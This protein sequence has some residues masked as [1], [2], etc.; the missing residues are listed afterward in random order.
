MR[1]GLLTVLTGLVL[2]LPGTL[3]ADWHRPRHSVGPPEPPP[4][5]LPPTERGNSEPDAAKL[6]STGV[7]SL[8]PI[9]AGRPGYRLLREADAQC[10]AVCHAS[11]ANLL[12][13]ERAQMAAAHPSPAKCKSVFDRGSRGWK[14]R[15]AI[16]YYAALEDRN[17]AAGQALPLYFKAAQL[18]AQ[19]NLLQFSR[20]E[21]AGS[22]RKSEELSAKGFSQ[23][24]D[25]GALKRQLLDVEA[26]MVRARAGLVEVNGRLKGLIGEIDCDGD[27]LW[28]AI[29]VP[30]NFEGVDPEAAVGIAL[31]HR[32]ELLLLREMCGD[33]DKETLP[34]VRDYLH[35]VSGLL[36][37]S[38]GPAKCVAST[39]AVLKAFLSGGD[40]EKESR[41]SQIASM[42]ADRE[43]AV[44]AEVRLAVADFHAK[45]RI[46]AL[47]RDRVQSA[48]Q[49]RRDAEQ[50]AL[51]AG[52]TFLEVTSARLDWFKARNLLTVDVMAWHTARAK[53]RE[54]QGI[55][56]WECCEEQ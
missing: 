9:V 27:W 43:R 22:I 48:D 49:H 44:A 15:R 39:L 18:E 32:P 33:L 36:G 31:T 26:D 41:Q 30:V 17:R 54:T 6:P 1:P 42:L 2:A 25:P 19:F 35:A 46:V 55:F 50:K 34:V 38:T 5:G 23:P 53:V 56:V 45:A 52:G 47:S 12:D 20:D 10:L 28:P 7:E 24:G 16:L 4:P 8:P 37:T 21:L 51:R 11:I 40:G 14:L 3:S 29:E 13:K